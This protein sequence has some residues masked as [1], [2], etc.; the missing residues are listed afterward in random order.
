[1]TKGSRRYIAELWCKML[2]PSPM[3]PSHGHDENR[4]PVLFRAGSLKMTLHCCLNGPARSPWHTGPGRVRPRRLR[5]AA[6]IAG[7]VE[8]TL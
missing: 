2:H 1:M 8:R 7:R 5:S 4:R 6:P 3:W